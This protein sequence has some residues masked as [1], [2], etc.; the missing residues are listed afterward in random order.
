[1]VPRQDITDLKADVA[2]LRSDLKDVNTAEADLRIQQRDLAQLKADFAAVTDKLEEMRVALRAN[3]AA[4]DGCNRQIAAISHLDPEGQRILAI[5]QMRRASPEFRKEF[6]Q[7]VSGTPRGRKWGILRITNIMPID[8]YIL[9]D[10]VQYL[11]SRSS[12]REIDVPVGEVKTELPGCESPHH[13]WIGPP[14]YSDAF[15]IQPR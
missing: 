10:D 9:V 6:A 3:V 12:V 15:T 7:A 14:N 13:H 8:Q 2:R 4:V 5:E 11:I 1:V